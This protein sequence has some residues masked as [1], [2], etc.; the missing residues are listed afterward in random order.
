MLWESRTNRQ[1]TSPEN[2][3][4]ASQKTRASPSAQSSDSKH[5]IC[6]STSY[7]SAFAQFSPL[8]AKQNLLQRATRHPRPMHNAHRKR[9]GFVHNFVRR[10]Q[11]IHDAKLQRR[12]RIEHVA[13]VKQLRR[14]CMPDQLRQKNTSRRNPEII[15]LSQTSRQNSLSPKR[16]ECPQPA[17][18]S[19]PLQP[20]RRS[21]Q[22]RPAAASCESSAPLPCPSAAAVPRSS[23]SFFCRPSQISF[24]SPP[25]QNALPAPVITTA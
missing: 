12:L 2:S 4:S 13:V 22:Q 11:L 16:S 6:S 10:H 23:L 9:L 15:R 20:P 3:A 1:T 19:S 18:C 24:R 7:S 17:Q 14:L 5:R 8:V 25:A 21:P